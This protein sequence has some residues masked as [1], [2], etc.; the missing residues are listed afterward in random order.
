MKIAI[1]GHTSGIG[2]A[3][4]TH[5]SRDNQVIGFSRS[6]GHDIT[7]SPTRHLI[8]MQTIDCDVIINNAYSNHDDSQLELLKLLVAN[9]NPKQIIINISSRYTTDSY[10]YCQ[11]KLNL[12][13]YCESQVFNRQV[14]LV[15]IKPGLV[16]TP[17][18]ANNTGPKVSTSDL[19]T[20]IEFAISN[21][22]K[23]TIHTVCF[24]Q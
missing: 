15:N 16:D 22:D 5:Y 2:L 4:Y 12:D 9:S 6:T 21:I 11:A 19:I 8:A 13:R 18:V 7:L 23:F 20:V 14:K 3:L 1:T 24:G 10:P 17:R